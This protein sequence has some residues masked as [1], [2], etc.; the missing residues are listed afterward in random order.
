MLWLHAVS[1]G[2]VK[3]L[4]RFIELFLERHPNWMIA[5]SQTTPTGHEVARIFS[6]DRVMAFYAPF[7]LSGCVSRVLEAIRPKMITLVESEIWP[8]LVGEAFSRGIPIGVINGRMSP[9]SF[10]MYRL[11]GMC[12]RHLIQKLSFCLVQTERDYGYFE[13]LGVSKEKIVICGN[14]KFDQSERFTAPAWNLFHRKSQIRR[15]WV[16]GSTSGGEEQIILDVFKKLKSTFPD[17]RLVLAPRHLER[18]DLVSEWIKQRSFQY[19]AFSK[20]EEGDDS[21]VILIDVM[22]VLASVYQWADFVFVGGSFTKR[23]GQNPVEPAR[24]KKAILHGPHVHNFHALYELLDQSG[25]AFCVS[26]KKMLYER[27]K[28]LLGSI[29][30]RN[31]VG[32][33]AFQTIER[34]KGATERTLRGLEPWFTET[35]S[36][37]AGVNL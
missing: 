16:V 13:M 37:Y 1:V 25:G 6:S 3:A 26:T 22:G 4:G 23:G 30:L 20:L 12:Y 18:M 9:R 31:E 10:K 14:L 32:E 19:T 36:S 27:S 2:E 11:L 33:K 17:L 28:E 24:F 29:Q 5:F 7:D 35:P 34:M 21:E 8:N 15:T